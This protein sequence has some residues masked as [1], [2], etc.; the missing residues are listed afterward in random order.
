MLTER[1]ADAWFAS[2]SAYLERIC[3]L[4]HGQQPKT[5]AALLAHV[6]G[7][8][9]PDEALWKARFKAH[10]AA[11][12]AAIPADQ[13]LVLDVTKGHGYKE[14]CAFLGRT[15]GAC[16]REHFPHRNANKDKRA[17]GEEGVACAETERAKRC[18]V[19]ADAPARKGK[20]AY[21]L[22]LAGQSPSTWADY[23]R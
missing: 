21:V 7:S 19:P 11:V 22:S 9:Q 18:A 6:Y 17:V 15:G 16:K 23:A 20:R 2:F 13:L 4:R 14:L 1:D 12:R 3:K 10:N 5:T 8:A